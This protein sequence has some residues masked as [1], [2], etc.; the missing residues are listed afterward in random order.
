[1]TSLI[2]TSA[3]HNGMSSYELHAA[4]R[5][6]HAGCFHCSDGT[7]HVALYKMPVGVLN[8]QYTHRLVEMAAFD[9][10][11]LAALRHMHS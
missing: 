7:V 10:V 2:R 11:L 6:L 4:Q 1:M 3:E 5:L 9:L 8:T